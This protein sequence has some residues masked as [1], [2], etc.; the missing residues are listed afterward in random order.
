[1]KNLVLILALVLMVSAAFANRP[2]INESQIGLVDERIPDKVE[3]RL[4]KHE[5]IDEDT[6][7]FNKKGYEMIYV[8]ERIVNEDGRFPDRGR[9]DPNEDSLRR[10]KNWLFRKGPDVL[11]ADSILAVSRRRSS[12]RTRK[13]KDWEA[14]RPRRNRSGI[15]R[16]CWFS[17]IGRSDTRLACLRSDVSR[18]LSVHPTGEPPVA[19]T[20]S[21]GR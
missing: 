17:R 10:F 18:Y 11:P 12:S 13:K 19:T 20:K 2:R 3:C 6:N 4:V 15:S 16:A 21:I 5:V 9:L 14:N 7:M 8:C 1:M